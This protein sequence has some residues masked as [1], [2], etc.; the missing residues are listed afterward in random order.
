MEAEYANGRTHG[1]KMQES[2]IEILSMWHTMAMG[3][4]DRVEELEITLA[5]LAP[6]QVSNDNSVRRTQGHNSVRKPQNKRSVAVFLAEQAQAQAQFQGHS[7]DQDRN[8]SPH[9]GNKHHGFKRLECVVDN[10]KGER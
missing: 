7:Q 6:S 9:F 10:T 4:E 5:D 3:L 8:R 2:L 1:I